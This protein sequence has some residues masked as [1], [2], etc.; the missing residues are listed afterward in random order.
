[1]RPAR[2]SAGG[3][4]YGRQKRNTAA[5]EVG[6]VDRVPGHEREVVIERRPVHQVDVFLAA[7][8]LVAR[9]HHGSPAQGFGGCPV[10][11]TMFFAGGAARPPGRNRIVDDAASVVR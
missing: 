5:V 8:A 9:A 2:N 7:L 6:S 4:S 10:Q 11:D 1:M 3:W